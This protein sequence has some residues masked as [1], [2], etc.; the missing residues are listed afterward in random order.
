[1]L[2][3]S[4]GITSQTCDLGNYRSSSKGAFIFRLTLQAGSVKYLGEIGGLFLT[5]PNDEL[6]EVVDFNSDITHNTPMP[7]FV[8]EYV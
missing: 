1:M 5:Y 2:K 8:I 7:R 4:L 6:V 3:R